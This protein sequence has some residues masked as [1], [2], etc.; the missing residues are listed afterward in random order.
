MP[1]PRSERRV[2]EGARG[3]PRRRGA[4]KPAATPAAWPAFSKMR[5]R[6]FVALRPPAPSTVFAIV[7]PSATAGPSGPSELP[8]PSVATAASARANA[9]AGAA[10]GA[11][12]PGVAARNAPTASPPSAGTDA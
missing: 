12:K 9:G 11:S 10:P 6:R 8:V 2:F 1:A 4:E 5:A 7:V 3:P